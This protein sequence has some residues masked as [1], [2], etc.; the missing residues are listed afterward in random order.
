MTVLLPKLANATRVLAASADAFIMSIDVREGSARP[1]D[2]FTVTSGWL[3]EGLNSPVSL[4]QGLKRN[5]RVIGKL[6]C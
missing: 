3:K 2:M 5:R 1:S 6:G 4:C